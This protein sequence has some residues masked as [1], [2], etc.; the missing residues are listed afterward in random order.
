[1]NESTVTHGLWGASAPP[2]PAAPP[3]A[4]HAVA[5]A[6]VVG[7]GFTGCSAA[8]H[9]AL[10][11]WRVL[12][13][14]AKHVGYGAS[15]RNVGL[16][17]AGMWVMPDELPN[18]LGAKYGERL[19]HQLGDAPQLVFDLIERHGIACEARR[20]GT[21]HCA[22]G[23]NGVAEIEQRAQQWKKRRAD[24]EV[25]NESETAQRVGTTAYSASLLDRR[26]GTIQPLAYV[27][28]LAHAAIAAGAVFH[29]QSPVIGRQDL[30]TSW[31]L[32]T[33]SGSAS[34]P[35][36]I[37]ATDVYS[38]EAFRP[39]AQGQV[40]LPYFN[41]ATAPLP[42][43]SPC[44]DPS[45]APGRLGYQT[46]SLVV[47]I[48]RRRPTHFRQRRRPARH[49]HADSSG[50]GPAGTATSVSTAR[51]HRL[52]ARVVRNDRHDR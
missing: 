19:L 50:L 52:S 11:G 17:N 32:R 49:G 27:R 4:K 30:G 31:K 47:P 10:G 37:V 6:V 7:A 38:S 46:D 28:G 1:M 5:D 8:L 24:V 21:I 13:L 48:R 20:S 15:G 12:V 43:G 14:E 40:M 39:L 9:L 41:L 23:K 29:G 26:A 2:G 45:G 34:A 36:V 3:L 51:V 42:R 22:V 16:V 25:L 33:P 44:I 18:I 35:W